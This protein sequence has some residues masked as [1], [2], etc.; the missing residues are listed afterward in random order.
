MKI[1]LFKQVK[2]TQD[3]TQQK[4]AKKTA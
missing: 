1:V 4:Q 2:L 3:K